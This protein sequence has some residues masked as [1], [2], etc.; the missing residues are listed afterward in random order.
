MTDSLNYFDMYTKLN[1]DE[2][3]DVYEK[4]PPARWIKFMFKYF[5]TETEAH[6]LKPARSITLLLLILFIIGFVATI[7]DLSHTLRGMIT[8][9]YAIVLGTVVLFILFAGWM[10]NLRINRIRKELGI[11]VAEYNM[12][13]EIW[14]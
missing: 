4:H 14:L 2:F 7:A 10:N 5:S 9:S 8:Y 3:L 12:A 1:G 13:A 6:N 11:S